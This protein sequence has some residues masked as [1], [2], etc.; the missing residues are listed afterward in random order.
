MLR[1]EGMGGSLSVFDPAL[2]TFKEMGQNKMEVR[3][4]CRATLF[5]EIRSVDLLNS[6]NFLLQKRVSETMTNMKVN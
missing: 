5:T 6:A 3:Q 2:L 1:R 4:C